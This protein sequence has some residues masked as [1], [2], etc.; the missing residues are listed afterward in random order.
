MKYFF[1][2]P[3]DEFNTPENC[4]VE[5]NAVIRYLR[6][7]KGDIKTVDIDG[8]T[9]LLDVRTLDNV[10]CFD[11]CLSCVKCHGTDC[12]LGVPY[13]MEE[14]YFENIASI[15]N[16]VISQ[17]Y[18][19]QENLEFIKKYGWVSLMGDAQSEYQ[20]F[21]DTGISK[22]LRNDGSYC[23]FHSFVDDISC[24][25]LHKYALENGLNP[26]DFKPPSCFM[27]PLDAIELDNEKI[28]LFGFD[29]DTLP[30]SRWSEDFG[31]YACVNTSLGKSFKKSYGC[32]NKYKP[33]YIEQESF[34]RNLFSDEL[35]DSI[36]RI[37]KGVS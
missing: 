5:D 33:I 11:G 13:S 36:V 8:R 3:N 35:Y 27:F 9:Y 23:V 22:T 19:S 1:L 30:F 15:V 21:D 25:A 2:N 34:I 37:M 14:K 32:F 26:Y 24:C 29:E 16:D 31:D 12:C 6:A 7:N 10:C 17:P 18:F 4:L 20:T 28:F